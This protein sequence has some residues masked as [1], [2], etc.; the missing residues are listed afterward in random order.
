MQRCA[1]CGLGPPRRAQF[2]AGLGDTAICDC[3]TELAVKFARSAVPPA[4]GEGIRG[5]T[6]TGSC[7]FCG[8]SRSDCQSG[9]L[10]GVAP[11]TFICTDC[12]RWA[13][14]DLDVG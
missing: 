12:Q 10:V 1:F 3:C 2:F 7:R 8:R 13:A 5:G 6:A 4:G 11:E 14:H 9:G